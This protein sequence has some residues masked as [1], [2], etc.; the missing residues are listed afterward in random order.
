M[1]RAVRICLAAI[2]LA[3]SLAA[4]VPAAAAGARR[5]LAEGFTLFAAGSYEEAAL[6]FEDAVARAAGEGLDPAA[7]VYDLGCALLSAGKAAEAAAAFAEAAGSSDREL[8]AKAHYNR[9]IALA[10]AAEAAEKAG[11]LE[12]AVALLDQALGSYEGAMRADPDDEDPKVNHELAFRAK[13]RLENRMREQG[14]DEKGGSP[15]PQRPERTEKRRQEGSPGRPEALG[16]EMRP[17]E[18]RTMLD[19][20]RQQEIS[21]RSRI[22]PSRGGSAPVDKP[23]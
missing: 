10:T 8:G 15:P 12:G 11:R 7:A 2:A 9:G 18:A 4:P 1:R 22:R 20:M 16:D 14:R 6:R 3:A 19:A 17:A 23:W 5:A 21:Q 13:A